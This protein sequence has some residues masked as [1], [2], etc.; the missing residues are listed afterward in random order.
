MT[1][2]QEVY[3]SKVGRSCRGDRMNNKTLISENSSGFENKWIPFVADDDRLE[4]LCSYLVTDGKFVTSAYFDCGS[5][6]GCENDLIAKVTHWME[7]P[8]PPIANK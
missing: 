7:W 1:P 4:S 3:G 8:T 5:F 2:L 6:V